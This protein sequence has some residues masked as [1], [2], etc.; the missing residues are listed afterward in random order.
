MRK[1]ERESKLNITSFN[2]WVLNDKS[3]RRWWDQKHKT[4]LIQSTSNLRWGH[5]EFAK[6]TQSFNL[7]K[8]IRNVNCH[9]HPSI[10]IT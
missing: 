2:N 10:F 5:F 3:K 1:Y 8:N 4:L 9:F 7:E 6:S